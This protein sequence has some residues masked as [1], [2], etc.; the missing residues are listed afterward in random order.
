VFVSTDGGTSFTPLN[1]GFGS[2][3]PYVVAFFAAGG[4]LVG[5][6]ESAGIWRRPL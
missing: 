3:P 5:V 6:T 2:T 4:Y 1:D